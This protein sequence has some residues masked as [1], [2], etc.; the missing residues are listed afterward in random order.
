V[1]QFGAKGD[2][3]TDDSDAINRAIASMKSG[4]TLVFEQGK[5]Y[6][7]TKNIVVN[8]P[9]VH[10]WG[11]GSTIM[12]Q[13][14]APADL[15]A[16]PAAAQ[17]SIQ[18]N[19]PRTAA[20]G[21][22]ILSR[23]QVRTGHPNQAGIVL[24]AADVVAIDNRIEYAGNGIFV[25]MA[26]NFLVARNVVYRTVADGIHITTGSRDGRVLCNVVRETGD[27]MIAV[28][29]YGLGEPNIF[30]F[31]IEAN[32]VEGNYWGRGITVVGGSD[33]TIRGNRIAK[34]TVGAAVYIASEASY[35][36]ANVRNVVVENN[37]ILDTQMTTPVYNPRSDTKRTG[38][39]AIEII[40][41][42]S[43][44]IRNVLIRNNRID[45]AFRDGIRVRG[46]SCDIGVEN[47]AMTAIGGMPMTVQPDSQGQ[48]QVGCAGNTANGSATQAN[49]CTSQMPEVR[50][51][52]Q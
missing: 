21:M 33:V 15:K 17:V 8:N 13:V 24:A 2:G 28:V 42:G 10:L 25:R 36:T 6:L 22:T 32:D 30:N 11:Y 19:A 23:L 20:Y 44:Q 7:K 9:G 50:G 51:A 4:G 37:D 35:K 14:P 26:S 34:A 38:H 5:T 46:N 3:V 39:G 31:R 29:N 12:A 27:D 48:C 43:Q 47:N 45:R 1:G 16:A 52:K 41:Q 49:A 18:L 40:G